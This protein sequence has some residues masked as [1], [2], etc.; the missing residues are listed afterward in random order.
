MATMNVSLPDEMKEWAEKQT[1]HGEYA[2]VSDYV[3]DL[4][5]RDMKRTEGVARLQVEIDK[6]RAGPFYEYN[7]AD[8]LLAEVKQGAAARLKKIDAA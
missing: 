6:G 2:N 3:R 4:I 8:E 7:S 1:A 5:R